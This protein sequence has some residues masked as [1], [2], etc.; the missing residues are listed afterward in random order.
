MNLPCDSRSVL[1]EKSHTTRSFYS[2]RRVAPFPDARRGALVE[3]QA[4]ALGCSQIEAEW[5]ARRPLEA[6]DGQP[7]VAVERGHVVRAEQ[8]VARR[9]AAR[10]HVHRVDCA[11]LKFKNRS[12][13]CL[14]TEQS[15]VNNKI[16][17]SCVCR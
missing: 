5:A 14:Q 6:V 7:A 17:I 16:Q 10:L 3:N 1:R 11:D 8:P 12:N 2:R 15:V 13:R 9:P 4:S